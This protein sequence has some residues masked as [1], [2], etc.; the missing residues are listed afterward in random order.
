MTGNGTYRKIRLLSLAFLHL[1][2]LYF[3]YSLSL[4]L[5]FLHHFPTLKN[6]MNLH[7]QNYSLFIHVFLSLFFFSLSFSPFSHQLTICIKFYSWT[8]TDHNLVSGHQQSNCS[9]AT[10]LTKLNVTKLSPSTFD[11][12]AIYW[13]KLILSPSTGL[14]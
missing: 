7:N 4:Y 9:N 3:S 6:G 12:V 2:S 11:F 1:F 10:I 5:P 13:T 8:L 14:N